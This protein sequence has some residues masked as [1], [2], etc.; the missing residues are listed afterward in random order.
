MTKAAKV[1][2]ELGRIPVLVDQIRSVN[3]EFREKREAILR[4]EAYSDE[5]KAKL[6]ADARK[7]ADFTIEGLTEQIEG[8]KAQTAS[9]LTTLRSELVPSGAEGIAARM[10]AADAR[11]RVRSMVNNGQDIREVLGLAVQRSDRLMIEAVKEEARWVTDGSLDGFDL[12]ADRALLCLV[13]PE[14]ADVMRAENLLTQ[15]DILLP[16]EIHKASEGSTLESSV[17]LHYAKVEAEKIDLESDK[18]VSI[19]APT[20]E[21][22][23]GAHLGKAAADRQAAAEGDGEATVH[24]SLGAAVDANYGGEAA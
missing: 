2:A 5:G 14:T 3:D 11:D 9:Q 17:S 7:I 8:I 12:A 21:A 22:A 13:D 15:Q 4:Y 10:E 1:L 20:L 24:H 16:H 18:F 6:T 19:G 23:I